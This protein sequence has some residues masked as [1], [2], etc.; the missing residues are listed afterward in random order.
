MAKKISLEGIKL[1]EPTSD[2][3]ASKLIST[4]QKEK[5]EFT[6]EAVEDIQAQIKQREQLHKEVIEGFEN[7]KIELNNLMLSTADM[8]EQ[9]KARIRQ[10]QADLEQFKVQET[11]DKWKDIALLKKEL[12]ERIQEFKEKESRTEMMTKLLEQ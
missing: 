6:K 12:R 11:I 8:E 7:I 4:L 2:K 9:E 10:K 3:S 5:V 1:T